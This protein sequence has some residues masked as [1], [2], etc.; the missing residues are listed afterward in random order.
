MY[1][2]YAWIKPSPLLRSNYDWSNNNR[3]HQYGADDNRYVRYYN[4]KFIQRENN[5]VLSKPS[6]LQGHT[7]PW[8]IGY[9]KMVVFIDIFED[10]TRAEQHSPVWTWSLQ[11]FQLSKESW[12]DL[13]LH[14]KYSKK[15]S[16]GMELWTL[17]HKNLLPKVLCEPLLSGS[18]LNV[19]RLRGRS[20]L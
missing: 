17:C 9:R 3:C 12:A 11:L 2:H 1:C 6:I 5:Y 16:E 20:S 7:N 14:E 19:G 10:I 18:L 4:G 15:R 13:F 8:V